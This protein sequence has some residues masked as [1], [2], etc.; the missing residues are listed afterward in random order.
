MIKQ[1]G[2]KVSRYEIFDHCIDV[3]TIHQSEFTK[4]MIIVV[5]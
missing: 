2:K 4:S 3:S 1:H 5:V